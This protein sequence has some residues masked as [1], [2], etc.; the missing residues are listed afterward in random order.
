MASLS[1]THPRRRIVNNV[2]RVVKSQAKDAAPSGTTPKTDDNDE[3]KLAPLSG[4][5]EIRLFSY[6]APSLQANLHTVSITHDIY[7]PHQASSLSPTD[8]SLPSKH[9]QLKSTQ[10]FDVYGLRFALPPGIVHQT[11]PPQGHGDHS[12][13]LPHIVFNDA[14]FPWERDISTAE[15]VSSTPP[16]RNLTPWLAILVFTE[17]ELKLTPDQLTAL[18]AGQAK[19]LGAA[20]LAQSTTTLDVNML[21]GNVLNLKTGTPGFQ[22]AVAD[23]DPGD[24][25]DPTQAVNMIFPSAELFSS[26]FCSYDS[27]WNRVLPASEGTPAVV[28]PDLSRYKYMAHVKQVS[29]AAMPDNSDTTGS[30]ED[31]MGED[32]G[33][34]SVIISHRTGPLPGPL[35]LPTTP[36]AATPAVGAMINLPKSAIVHLVSLQGLEE[37]INMAASGFMTSRVGLVSLYSWTYNVLPPVGANFLDSMRAIGAQVPSESLLRTPDFLLAQL[38]NNPSLDPT[39]VKISNRLY[40]RALDGASLVRYMPQTGEETI[41]FSRGAL[42]PTLPPHPLTPFW[43]TESNFSTNLQV[44]DKHLGMTDITYSSA[45]ELGRTLAIADRSFT[46]SLNRL[47]HAVNVYATNQTKQNLQGSNFVSK[48]NTIANLKNGVKLLA[49]LP[50]QLADGSRVVDPVRLWTVSDS[51]ATVPP[52]SVR[53][54]PETRALFK[55]NVHMAMAKIASAQSDGSADLLPYNEVNVPSSPDWAVVLKWV[56]DKMYLYNIPAHY[57][58]ADP[59]YLPKESIRFFYI[60]P[61]WID[62]LI[63][64]ALSIG[65]HLETKDDIARQAFKFQLNQY[66]KN[67]LDATL[68]PYNPQIPVYGFLLR[69]GVVQAYPNLEVHAPWNPDPNAPWSELVT[70]TQPKDPRTQVLRSDLLDKDILLCLFDRQPGSPNFEELIVMQPPHQQRYTVGKSFG[71]NTDPNDTGYTGINAVEVEFRK[72]YTAPLPAQNAYTALDTRVWVEGKGER[73]FTLIENEDPTKPA[74]QENARVLTP[75]NPSA[76]FDFESSAI[77]VPAFAEAC[78]NTL[79]QEMPT[80]FTDTVPSSALVGLQLAD[81][82][83]YLNI[84]IPAPQFPT[85]VPPEITSAL[86]TRF[87]PV[88]DIPASSSSG[89]TPANTGSGTSG[90]PAA[91]STG[92]AGTSTTGGSTTSQAAVHPT[93]SAPSAPAPSPPKASPPAPTIRAAPG[94]HVANTLLRTAAAVPASPPVSGNI[95]GQFQASAFKLGDSKLSPALRP[96]P[97]YP[98]NA[99]ANIP[100]DLIFAFVPI[101]K[102]I[103]GLQ[104]NGVKVLI[105]MGSKPSDLLASYD[106]EFGAGA[107]MLSNLRFNTILSTYAET[108]PQTGLK[109]DFLVVSLVPRS[110]TQLV[111]LERNPDVSFVLNQAVLNGV[112]GVATCIVTEAYMKLDGTGAHNASPGTNKITVVKKAM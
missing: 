38:Q 51:S 109:Q 70:P 49:D 103:Q 78:V 10:Q 75:P 71:P 73:T 11:Y 54:S 56:V 13:V 91:G 18:G 62:A 110:T 29:Q 26:L 104:L 17:D 58:I 108:I 63:D 22:C 43:P 96:L 74:T 4:P 47:R 41:A 94:P 84:K 12:E 19:P 60:D 39:A 80:F 97:V 64:G 32:E 36:K 45:W 83:S 34:Y 100:L 72:V 59:T 33:V 88:P 28:R 61:N 112:P 9:L 50:T 35:R 25:I 92:Q 99:S 106:T 7:A 53:R 57:L 37:Y 66:F 21:L 23:D 82:L 111:P 93:A 67:P 1:K 16:P 101:L 20:S 8:P 76:I 98:S 2:V 6:Y 79:T 40:K 14:H 44:I 95:P 3:P 86:G 48:R 46:A 87:F 15:S 102:Q 31:G 81:T 55:S 30:T 85:P 89:G 68:H 24:K 52:T 105:P 69:S 107:R 42:T 77:I 5:G 27:N 90:Q 65:N